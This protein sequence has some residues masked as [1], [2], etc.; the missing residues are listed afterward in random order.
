[1]LFLFSFEKQHG[2]KATSNSYSIHYRDLLSSTRTAI[3]RLAAVYNHIQ[4]QPFEHL[5]S[6]HQSYISIIYTSGK[7]SS[8]DDYFM[9]DRDSS[10]GTETRYRLDCP[11]IE[12]RC[13][14]DFSYS[15]KTVLGSPNLLQ[16]GYRVFF[17]GVKRPGCGVTHP[18][19]IKSRG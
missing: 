10:V 6:F 18:T 4:K 9:L 7:I 13:S 17:T 1:M 14:R 2:D 3:L 5:T 16:H 12:S 15:S 19:H 8:V 11:G